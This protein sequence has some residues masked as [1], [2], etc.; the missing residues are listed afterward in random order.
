MVLEYFSANS[1]KW[2]PFPRA[3]GP[4]LM[5][6]REK[7]Q[8]IL[9]FLQDHVTSSPLRK[10]CNLVGKCHSQV[11]NFSSESLSRVCGN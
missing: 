3:L 5:K 6:D 7:L 10:W 11:V 4:A 1:K 8:G 9:N 2:W